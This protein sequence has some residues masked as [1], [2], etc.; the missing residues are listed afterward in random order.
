[1][2]EALVLSAV[3]IFVAEL[4]DKSQLLAIAFASRFRVRD[5]LIGITLATTIVHLGS[6]AL[7][8]TLGAQLAR[9]TGA[10]ELATGIAFLGFALWTARGDSIDDSDIEKSQR[11]GR[12]AILGVAGAFML[13]EL[14]DKTMLATVTLAAQH[15][16]IGTWI[17]STV[18]MVA[19]DALAVVVAAQVGKRLPLRTLSIVATIAF[20]VIGLVYVA[21]GLPHF[22]PWLP[23]FKGEL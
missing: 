15:E 13:A 11:F 14:G 19:A 8:A 7:G 6:V 20:A 17:G 2:W 1:M 10:V 16:V 9:H 21:D 3:V 12:W 5:V 18:G 23:H 22:I 4:G